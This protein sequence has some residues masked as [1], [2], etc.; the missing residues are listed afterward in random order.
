MYFK[1]SLRNNPNS[2]KR[3]SS[4]YRLVESYRNMYGR[5]CHRTILNVGFL[6]EAEP[7]PEQLNK[8]QKELSNRVEGK[9]D[10]FEEQ[11]NL[12]IDL[13]EQFWERIVREKRVDIVDKSQPKKLDLNLVKVDSIKHKEVREIGAEWL[14]LQA[15]NQ[16]GIGDFLMN[17]GWNEQKVKLTITQIIA[18]AI[19][20]ASELKTTSWIK[21]NSGIC[22]LTGYP[23]NK[24]TK[25][26]LYTNALDLYEIKDDLENYLSKKTNEL[27]EIDDKIVLFD[28]TNT[29][30]EGE[31]RNSKLA[32]FGRSKEKRSD[33][34][35]VVLA[36]VVNPEG[37]LKYSSVFEGNTS[38]PKTLPTIIDNLR[39]KTSQNKQR[40]TVVLDAGIATEENLQL[41]EEKGYDYVCVSRSKLKDYAIFEGG[42][43]Q[44]VT[45]NNKDELSLQRVVNSKNTDYY[46]M[47]KSPGKVKK[48]SG[49]NTQFEARFEQELEKIRHGLTTKHGT[50]KADKVERRIGRAIEKYP[51]VARFYKIET[52]IDEDKNSSTITWTKNE[53]YE[54]NQEQFGV[55]FIRTNLKIEQEQTL[56]KIYNTIR[57]IEYSFRTLKTDLDLRPIYHKSDKSTLAHL[58]LGLLAYWLVNTIRFQL[59]KEGINNNWNELVRIA[60]TQ[61]IVT[62]T[63]RNQ[64]DTTIIIKRCSEPIESLTKLYD[65]LKYKHFP[66]TKRKSVVHKTEF[67]N[68]E[69]QYLLDISPH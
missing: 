14:N 33:A 22:E 45:T 10:L 7:E 46:L 39:V 9:T 35:I 21:E 17:L 63:A 31:K 36:I 50:K 60:N 12:V 54:Q 58:H 64:E 19:Y 52:Q 48:E 41:I 56:W 53:K 67:K 57:E 27:F 3:F 68:Q 20:P 4:Y 24:I 2:N 47:V 5:V 37:F 25:D 44:K 11:D 51:S 16:L 61:K 34:K 66:F 13:T 62:T 65:A 55:Y 26:K 49:M 18:R 30:F 28:L 8:I 43:V 38:D 59:K 69:V 1:S 23:L 32:Q 15:L 42:E 29:Y 40:A 6:D